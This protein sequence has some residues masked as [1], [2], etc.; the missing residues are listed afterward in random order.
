MKDKLLQVQQP[1]FKIVES[2]HLNG[3]R[4]DLYLRANSGLI[5]EY[6]LVYLAPEAKKR[7]STRFRS[8]KNRGHQHSKQWSANGTAIPYF[9]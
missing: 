6:I 1:S 7:I 2:T 8:N 3:P 4:L 9:P 5:V